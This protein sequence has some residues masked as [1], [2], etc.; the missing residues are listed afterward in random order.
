M[1]EFTN[2]LE[3]CQPNWLTGTGRIAVTTAQF[4][5]T[6]TRDEWLGGVLEYDINERTSRR[7]ELS[8]IPRNRMMANYWDAMRLYGEMK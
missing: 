4:N 5:A 3:I 1:I 6:C 8:Y 2:A 7:H